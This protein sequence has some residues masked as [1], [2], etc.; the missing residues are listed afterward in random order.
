MNS[1]IALPQCSQEEWALR[2]KLTQC[3]HLVDYFGGQKRFSTTFLRDYPAR[4]TTI[5]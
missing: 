1:A 4:N 5:W 2:T 3:Y